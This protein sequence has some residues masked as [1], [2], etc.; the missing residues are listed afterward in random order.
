MNSSEPK[1]QH[2]EVEY[3]APYL[4]IVSNKK[5]SINQTECNRIYDKYCKR[6]IVEFN[7]PPK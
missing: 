5:P 7:P 1:K 6:L 2:E 4:F 3:I